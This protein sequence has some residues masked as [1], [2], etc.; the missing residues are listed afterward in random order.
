MS[1][2]Q[3]APHVNFSSEDIKI[4]IEFNNG[5]N[6]LKT[7]KEDPNPPSRIKNYFTIA[8][9]QKFIL[10]RVELLKFIIPNR[11]FMDFT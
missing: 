8:R 3:H 4:E 5:I 9:E 7:Y 10:K 11:H 2:K 6:L 1:I